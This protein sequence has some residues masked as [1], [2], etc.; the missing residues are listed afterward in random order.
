G[1]NL[2]GEEIE[3]KLADIA[4]IPKIPHLLK[5]LVYINGDVLVGELPHNNSIVFTGFLDVLNELLLRS[6]LYVC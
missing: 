3:V 6:L 5:P 1:L 2:V 4:E